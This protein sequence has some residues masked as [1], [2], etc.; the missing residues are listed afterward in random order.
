MKGDGGE[1]SALLPQQSSGGPPAAFESPTF[2]VVVPVFNK[3]ELLVRSIGSVLAQTHSDL[4]LI[5]VND[6]STDG[7]LNVM[8]SFTDPRIRIINSTP[9]ARGAGAARNSGIRSARGK[10]IALLDADDEWTPV[11]IETMRGF[12]DK[13]VD[14]QLVSCGRMSKRVEQDE[15]AIDSYSASLECRDAHRIS[16]ARYLEL[17]IAERRPINSNSVVFK[18][19]LVIKSAPFPNEKTAGEDLV[20]W[21]RLVA[22]ADGLGWSPHIGSISYRGRKDAFSRTA[23]R[24][25]EMWRSLVDE[26]APELADEELGLLQRYANRQMWDAWRNNSRL[27]VRGERPLYRS[28]YWRNDTRFCFRSLGL[29]LIPFGVASLLRRAKQA[30]ASS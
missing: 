9:P 3:E 15:G 17:C 7:G 12:L 19:S 23:V 26:L 25:V 2:S 27:G 5:L 16:I 6:G 20:A 13:N 24:R 8:R 14:I 18:R 11:H 4:E 22:R 29:P 21:V 30:V 10:W 28:L 1:P